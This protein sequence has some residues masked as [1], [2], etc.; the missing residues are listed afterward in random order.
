[1]QVSFKKRVVGFIFKMITCNIGRVTA[2]L[3]MQ[4]MKWLFE[5]AS[6]KYNLLEIFFYF[7]HSPLPSLFAIDGSFFNFLVSQFDKALRN[8][9]KHL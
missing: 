5:A 9:V 2:G 3:H 6:A 4:V 7:F 1:M 8:F